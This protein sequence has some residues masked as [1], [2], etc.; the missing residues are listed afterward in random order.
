MDEVTLGRFF[1]LGD[2]GFPMSVIILPM[3]H[4]HLSSR[5][6]TA[7]PFLGSGTEDTVLII[8]TDG[9]TPARS[10]RLADTHINLQPLR[11]LDY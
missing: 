10:Q 4:S 9:T 5:A 6:G 1:S 11:F 7:G 3:V 8:V 2:F